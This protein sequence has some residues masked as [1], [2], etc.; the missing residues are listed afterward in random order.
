M[1][2]SIESGFDSQFHSL[3]RGSDDATRFPFSESF[4]GL[5]SDSNQLPKGS[6]AQ[7]ETEPVESENPFSPRQ[8]LRQISYADYEIDAL[9]KRGKHFFCY[10]VYIGFFT[11]SAEWDSRSTNADRKE[12]DRLS[13][14]N[15]NFSIDDLERAIQYNERGEWI[16]NT[17]LRTKLFANIYIPMLEAY[18]PTTF[19]VLFDVS[20][21]G[22]IQLVRQLERFALH[23]LKVGAMAGADPNGLPSLQYF[24]DDAVRLV[25]ILNKPVTDFPSI[26]EAQPFHQFD[27]ERR[28]SWEDRWKP[29]LQNSAALWEDYI[30]GLCDALFGLWPAAGTNSFHQNNGT[31]GCIGTL[32]RSVFHD[33][34]DPST[35][36]YI[37]YFCLDAGYIESRGPFRF[38]ATDN[39]DNHLLITE[40]NEI[41]FYTN[42]QR[43]ACLT[44]LSVL[45]RQGNPSAFDAL[46]CSRRRG[47]K[48]Q[49]LTSHI[50]ISLS[51]I[52][53]DLAT[54]GMLLFFQ[55]EVNMLKAKEGMSRKRRR[56]NDV[57]RYLSKPFSSL[58]RPS[59][60]IAKRIG[61][62]MSDDDLRYARAFLECCN[63]DWS[64]VVG[65]STLFRT[66]SPFK[67]RVDK[68]HEVLKAWKPR[69]VWQMRYAGY[70]GVDPVNLYAFYFAAMLGIATMIALGVTIA[71]TYAAFKALDI[72]VVSS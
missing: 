56:M 4:C 39:L 43:W 46:M 29:S 2:D 22:R 10:R 66:H 21:D 71:Q 72:N 63:D 35:V 67:D 48:P 55:D 60:H 40:R 14:L 53:G 32:L 31:C 27:L 3:A 25:H 7:V 12:R 68:L 50:R 65:Q 5:A 61:L 36:P 6:E 13:H 38:K 62:S 9:E 18:N 24:I 64:R 41:L 49:P 26:D 15:S 52:F 11:P 19:Q 44:S 33:Q 20:I 8:F 54:T 23:V 70:G 45:N 16:L 17:E 30:C 42:W 58:P 34:R 59:N 57:R 37:D 69:T 28:S 1:I 47:W 51:Q